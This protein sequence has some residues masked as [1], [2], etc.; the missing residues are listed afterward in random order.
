MSISDIRNN[1]VSSKLMTAAVTKLVDF[2]QNRVP[3]DANNPFLLGPFSPVKEEVFSTDLVVHGEIPSSL[4]GV[5]LRI[6]PNPIEVKNPSNY[7]WFVGDGMVHGLRLKEGKALWYKNRYVGTHRVH[8]KLGR[9]KIA[10]EPRSSNDIVNTSLIGHAG[11][12]WALIESG[13]LPIALDAELNSLQY[14]LFNSKDNYPFTAH[15]HADPDTGELHAICYDA[16][17]P[18]QVYYQ[19]VDIDGQIKKRITVPVKHGPMMHDCSMTKTKMLILDFPVTFSFGQM[20]KGT[21]LPYAWNVKHAARVG[22][23]PKEGTATDIRWFDVEPCMIFHTFNAYDLDNGDVVM[24]ACVHDKTFTESIQGPVDKQK[25]QFE[26]WTFQHSNNQVKREVISAIPQ[27]FPQIDERYTS[28]PYRFAYSISVGNEGEL[29]DTA[30]LNANNL[31]V[32]DLENGK[33]VKYSFGEE[34]ITG[35]V[36]FVPKHRDSEEGE[37]WLISYIHAIDATK[38]SK[39]V[40]LDSKR[41]GQEPQAIIDLPVRVPLGF[42]ANWVDEVI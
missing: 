1:I 33:T 25:I 28:K 31:L 23:L 30:N 22:L 4:N 10:G 13:P 41:I 16:L 37:G 12:I 42:H 36:V 9:K 14:G 3:Y 7:N 29:A 15:P 8:E 39:V 24:D 40:I 27:E 2:T 32:H 34:Y 38:P 26:R 21:Q 19:V 18:M 11:K 17:L 35:E 20:L 6:G 5:F